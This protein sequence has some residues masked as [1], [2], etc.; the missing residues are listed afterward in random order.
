MFIN[1]I[2]NI[3]KLRIENFYITLILLSPLFTIFGPAIDNINLVIIFT[4]SICLAIIHKR[5]L[6]KFTKIY[7]KEIFFSLIFV[8]FLIFSFLINFND[9]NLKF[10]IKIP[11][12]SFFI[13][14]IILIHFLFSLKNIMY[15]KVLIVLLNFIFY[16]ICILVIDLTIQ[17]FFFFNIFGIPLELRASSFFGKE[18]I[19]GGFLSKIF[20][21]FI[22]CYLKKIINLNKFLFIS[23]ITFFGIGLSGE[24]SAMIIFLI[25]N[26]FYWFVINYFKIKKILW[27]LPFILILICSVL[28]TNINRLLDIKKIFFYENYLTLSHD[29]VIYLLD[30]KEIHLFYDINKKININDQLGYIIDLNGNKK[31]IDFSKLKNAKINNLNLFLRKNEDFF[32]FFSQID[33]LN[34]VSI[35]KNKKNLGDSDLYLELML[36]SDSK[37]SYGY[38]D[39]GWGS[40]YLVALEMFKN[41][42]FIGTGPNSFRFKCNE[43]KFYTINSFNIGKSCTTHPHNLHIE[44]L[45]GTGIF[46]YV[47]FFLFLISI[48]RILIKNNN[49][50]VKEKKVILIIFLCF[51]PIILPT[52]SFFS[53]A[54]MN[55]IFIF[56]MILQI[57]NSYARYKKI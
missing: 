19:A 20:P 8:F 45:Q 10:L 38:F 42:I 39:S 24:R 55:R 22:F 25:I 2:H 40:H 23:L 32:N 54:M 9:E 30:V 33:H 27:L 4:L 35:Y 36:I 51:F 17:K 7:L 28:Y 52:G 15:P 14:N 44:I 37:V 11:Y 21:I 57:I 26:I 41:N 6:K 5:K 47:S 49:I 56:F 48:F 1:I 50:A 12:F 43:Q 13:F 16:L 29:P 31:N 53:T 46:G 3:I 18:L 34:D